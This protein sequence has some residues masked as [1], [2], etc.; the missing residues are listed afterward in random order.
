MA[1][2][3]GRTEARCGEPKNRAAMG[4]A[5]GVQRTLSCIDGEPVN[6]ERCELS[7]WRFGGATASAELSN[8]LAPAQKVGTRVVSRAR[9]CASRAAPVLVSATA[10]GSD[11]RR[12]VCRFWLDVS[13]DMHSALA[14]VAQHRPWLPEARAAA[15][16]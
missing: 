11:G 13:L 5:V 15:D 7:G 12:C 16:A 3:A 4:A 9:L 2:T 8:G 1:E 10:L 14:S 6:T